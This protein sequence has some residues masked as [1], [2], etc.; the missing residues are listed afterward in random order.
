MELGIVTIQRN[1]AKW[2]VEWFA[3]HYLMG[4]RKFFYYAH[5]CDDTTHDILANLSRKLNIKSNIISE[6]F[7]N[8]QLRA[9]QHACENYM[10]EVDWM[11]FI[12]GDE[13]LFSTNTKSLSSALIPYNDKPIS[14]VGVFNV[15][16]GSSG[17]IIEPDGLIIENY[18][19][20]A[21][22]DFA[23]Q[24]R[25]K[26]IVKGRQ[27]VSATMCSNVFKTQFGTVDEL[28]RPITWGY[29]P[30]Y[31]PTYVQFRFNHYVCQSYEYFKKFKQNSGH[32]DAS[33]S[34]ERPDE[35]WTNFDTNVI[36]D[37]SLEK[38]YEEVRSL[39]AQLV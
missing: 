34:G 3:F 26:S 7:D 31:E 19:M 23:A 33:A 38:Y 28:M 30:Q 17:H 21:G 15:N 37:K 2:L 14:A 1:R 18:R 9:Y 20:C 35:W 36:Y 16:F 32:A 27:T 12:D 10:N 25:V 11:A 39:V 5:M 13:F 8:V 4:F 24:R 6:R 22:L 29:V